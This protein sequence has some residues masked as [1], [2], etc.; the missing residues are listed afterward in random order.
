VKKALLVLFCSIFALLGTY[1][2]S[3]VYLAYFPPLGTVVQLQR[4]VEARLE[5]KPYRRRYQYA[6]LSQVSRDL[7]HAVVAAEDT[8]FFEH[9]GIDWIELQTIVETSFERG[10]LGRGGSTIT[11]QLVK[12][13]YFTTYRSAVR[14]VLEI[15]MALIA[16][17]ILSKKRIL[18][19][20]LNVIEWGPGIFGVE[21][22]S[23]YH[24][25]K[26]ASAITREEASR[27][28]ACIPAPLER[29]PQAMDHYSLLIRRRM[30]VMG[31]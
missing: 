2:L 13:L 31:W 20:Y 8:R 17:L 21:A 28:A 22:A 15:P 3:L 30:R 23:Q 26:P 11:Q 19:L 24:Y 16:E 12:N 9:S 4:Y 6:P 1:L 7:P 27:L 25:G 18:E 14:K 5:T 10:R 29:K